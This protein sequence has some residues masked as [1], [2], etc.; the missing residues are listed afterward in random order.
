ME[1]LCQADDLASQLFQ[2]KTFRFHPPRWIYQ[3]QPGQ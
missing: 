3:D 2:R 1:S